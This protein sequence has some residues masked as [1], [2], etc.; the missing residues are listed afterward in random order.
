MS[1][2]V[3]K[4]VNEFVNLIGAEHLCDDLFTLVEKHYSEE[5]RSYHTMDHLKELY[6]HFD[7]NKHLVHEKYHPI[8]LGAIIFH[9]I[10]Y[11]P[12]ARDNELQ[13]AN[14][15]RAWLEESFPEYKEKS[16][17][18]RWVADF[19]LYDY[20]DQH[21][22]PR[23][24]DSWKVAISF[25]HDLDFMI[26]ASSKLRYNQYREQIIHEYTRDYDIKQVTSGRAHFLQHK[27]FEGIFWHNYFI[28]LYERTAILNTSNE[29]KFYGE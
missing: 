21:L 26:L 27:L 28:E 13:S 25:F 14:F 22:E 8:V 15:F 11:Y 17:D 12:A 3:K 19:I 4:L 10:I 29:L 1:I 5:H 20:P 2:I 7:I 23:P 6:G 9:D 16:P 18:L 24:T